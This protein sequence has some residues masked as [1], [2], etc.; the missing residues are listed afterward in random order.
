MKKIFGGKLKRA[1]AE[2]VRE[3]TGIAIGGVPPAGHI[4]PLQTFL[5]EDLFQYSRVW[6]VVGI[7]SRSLSR[8]ASGGLGI[9]H[10]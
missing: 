10:C 4:E 9:M 3:A 6:A 2:F 8:E 1:D 5:D 7:P